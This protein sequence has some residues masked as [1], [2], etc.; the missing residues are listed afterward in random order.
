MNCPGK[1]ELCLGV[2]VHCLQLAKKKKKHGV[3]A[4]LQNKVTKFKGSTSFFS[5]HCILHQEELCAKCL[6]MDHITDTVNIFM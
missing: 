6:K 5:S 4:E 3:G 2:M 1:K